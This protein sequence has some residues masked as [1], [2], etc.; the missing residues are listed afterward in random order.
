LIHSGHDPA[1]FGK[2]RDGDWNRNPLSL[3]QDRDR[4]AARSFP[5]SFLKIG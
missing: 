3:V 1:L 5:R 4:C 2:G